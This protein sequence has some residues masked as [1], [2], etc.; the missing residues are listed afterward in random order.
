MQSPSEPR[1]LHPAAVAVWFIEDARRLVLGLVP[2]LIARRELWLVAVGVIVVLAVYEIFRW[3]RFS[4]RIE[5]ATLVVEGGLVSRYRR[6]LP[7]ARIQSVDVV[8]KLRHRVFDVIELRVETAGGSETEG[9]LVALEPTEVDRLRPLLLGEDEVQPGAAPDSPLVVLTPGDLVMAALTGG[10]VAVVAIIFGYAQ[11]VLG[12][13]LFDSIWQRAESALRSALLL[14]VIAVVS[15]IAL[16]LATSVVATILVYWNFTVRRQARRLTV[17]RGLLERRRAS[18][19]LTRVQAVQL[20]ENLLRRLLGKASLSVVTAGY[21]PRGDE[22][23]ETAMLLPIGDRS[24]ALWLAGLALDLPVPPDPRLHRARSAFV[25]RMVEAVALALSLI[26]V[27]LLLFGAR[28]LWALAL[29]APLALVA[30]LSYLGLGFQLAPDYVAVRTGVFN[31][32]TTLVPRSNVQHLVLTR[33]PVQRAFG[34][35]T[36]RVGVPKARPRA[37]DV[38]RPVAER[39]LTELYGTP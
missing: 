23:E 9:S 8:E 1:R 10:R 35:A 19:P 28:G 33:G 37:S 11:E 27:A 39:T 21:S 4:Y 14:T 31:R 6:A 12:D 7:F 22:R 32:R 5:G 38:E 20:N 26:V 36:V 15:V 2:L 25:R 30:W 34:L 13:E 29:L 16:V 3:L 18:V 24:R 17:E